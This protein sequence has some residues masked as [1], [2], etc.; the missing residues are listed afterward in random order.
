LQR[1]NWE[2]LVDHR[3][4]GIERLY[5]QPLPNGRGSE[6]HSEPRLL[7]RRSLLSTRI[8]RLYTRT[9]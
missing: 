8:L 5:R 6:T 4:I 7:G 3:Q 1:P 2:D 9:I